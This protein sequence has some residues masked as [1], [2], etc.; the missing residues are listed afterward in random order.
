MTALH[1]RWLITLIL[2]HNSL[3]NPCPLS[4]MAQ[5][6]PCINM[7][8]ILWVCQKKRGQGESLPTQ[9]Y[10]FC[11]WESH[12]PKDLLMYPWA[13]RLTPTNSEQRVNYPFRPMKT[14]LLDRD[15]SSFWDIVNVLQAESS[16]LWHLQC[17]HPP[18]WSYQ[19]SLILIKRSKHI[20]LYILTRGR[21]C[22]NIWLLSPT[23]LFV[24]VSFMLRRN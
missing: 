19:H 9:L 5:L 13:R 16:Q 4:F 7:N 18:A 23:V 8:D 20:K 2:K 10:I 1:W 14:V 24:C 12:K 22:E 6:W 11:D 21:R 15:L 3:E 17:L